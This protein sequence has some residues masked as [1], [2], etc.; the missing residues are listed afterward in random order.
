VPSITS[1]AQSVNGNL[2]IQ[3]NK[4]KLVFCPGSGGWG[5]PNNLRAYQNGLPLLQLYN[6]NEDIS[7]RKNLQSKYPHI[8][9]HLETLLTSYIE[10]GRST[11]GKQ[12]PNTINVDV[13]KKDD[14]IKKGEASFDAAN[15]P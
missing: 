15:K 7:E 9:A 14:Y 11:P 4:W 5:K 12:I 2:S 13:W 8:V 6:M 3:Q 10:K 1:I